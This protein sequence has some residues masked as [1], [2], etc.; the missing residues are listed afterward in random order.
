[1]TSC[2]FQ[3]S[4][5]SAP[6]KQTC[7][8]PSLES[9]ELL[10]LVMLRWRCCCWERGTIRLAQRCCC[11]WASGASTASALFGKTVQQVRQHRSSKWR[12]RWAATSSIEFSSTNSSISEDIN[13][14]QRQTSAYLQF[15]HRNLITRTA[16]SWFFQHFISHL[17]EEQIHACE[18]NSSQSIKKYKY[19]LHTIR[20]VLNNCHPYFNVNAIWAQCPESMPSALKWGSGGL[21]DS[22]CMWVQFTLLENDKF[23]RWNY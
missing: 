22:K 10:L 16:I 3:R 18:L 4:G 23:N 21:L 1:M 14:N 19:E 12:R 6:K 7:C 20:K 9:G 2:W 15:Y 11:C 17:N 5:S 13:S 8:L